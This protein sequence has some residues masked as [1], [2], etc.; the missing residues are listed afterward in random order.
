MTLSLLF[1]RKTVSH[2]L[3]AEG[4]FIDTQFPC[5]HQFFPV[6]SLKRQ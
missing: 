6:V 4:V 5:G 3:P 1:G 2:D